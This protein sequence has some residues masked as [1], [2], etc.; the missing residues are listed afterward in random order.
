MITR[1]VKVVAP[2]LEEHP[3]IDC[4][5]NLIDTIMSSTCWLLCEQDV[6]KYQESE[7]CLRGHACSL[8]VLWV[9]NPVYYGFHALLFFSQY[10]GT[11]CITHT[12]L[13]ASMC[14]C[15]AHAAGLLHLEYK[16]LISSSCDD[17]SVTRRLMVLIRFHCQCSWMLCWHRC[18]W[19]QH[20][21]NK[22]KN[23]S[24]ATAA[25]VRSVVGFLWMSTRHCRVTR[26]TWQNVKCPEDIKHTRSSLP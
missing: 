3:D 9:D 6:N 26:L 21:R 24:P 2:S 10:P 15:W 20:Q 18:T 25:M 1:H 23:L 8:W 16:L 12:A 5:V 7:A 19:P 17:V 4:A 14:E 22:F 13:S 11:L